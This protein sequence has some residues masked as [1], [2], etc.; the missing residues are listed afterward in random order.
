MWIYF[1]VT[2][3]LMRYGE[4]VL[5]PAPRESNR[6]LSQNPVNKPG[7]DGQPERTPQGKKRAARSRSDAVC[8]SQ[9]TR[10]GQSAAGEGLAKPAVA[11]AVPAASVI[12]T[13]RLSGCTAIQVLPGV[14][15]I[16]SP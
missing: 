9:E 16:S 11:A 10:R 13:S 5:A 8:C 6:L 2:L 7:P 4:S 12:S 3:R 1:F 14:K 15:M